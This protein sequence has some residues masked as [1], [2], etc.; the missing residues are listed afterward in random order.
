MTSLPSQPPSAFQARQDS[1]QLRVNDAANA[2]SNQGVRPTIARVR[3]ALGGGSPNDLAP[4][5][6]QWRNSELSRSGGTATFATSPT[7]LPL[8]IADLAHELWQRALASAVLEAKSGANSRDAVSRAA[9]A[10][11]LREHLSSLRDQLQRESLAYGELRVQSARHEAMAREALAREHSAAAR[12]R[13][14][15]RQVG[16]LRQRI[17][18]LEADSPQVNRTP[19]RRAATPQKSDLRK[20]RRSKSNPSSPTQRSKGA[21]RPRGPMSATRPTRRSTKKRRGRPK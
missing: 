6:K 12:E 16:A 11:L 4:A 15:I 9:E 13:D 3:S 18:E 2:L 17:S 8:Q 7:S 20:K 1:L 10:Q 14:L 19:P 5:L 21:Q